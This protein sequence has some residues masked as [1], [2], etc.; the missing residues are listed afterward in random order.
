M[1][2][3]VARSLAIICAIAALWYLLPDRVAGQT[4]VLPMTGRRTR[5]IETAHLF[6]TLFHDF[7]LE[8]DATTYVQ[9]GDIPAMWLRDSSAQT[10]PYIRYQAVY[11][12]LRARFA[13]VIERNA[14]NVLTDP[15]ANALDADYHVW[16]RKWEVDSPAWPVV[17]AW[18]Y[19]RSTQDRTVFTP[20]LHRALRTI[21]AT[22]DC[23]ERHR[24]CSRYV[25]PYRVQTDDTYNGGTG[26]IWGAFRPSDDAV[27]F[28]F[29]IPQNAMAV[30]AL[31]D[32]ERLALDGYGDAALANRARALEARVQVGIE[33]YGRYFDTG[34]H[35]WMYAYETDG[36]G[37]YNLMDDANIPN[38][39]TLPYIDWCSAFDP[40]YLATRKFALSAANPYFFSGRY[41]EGLGSPHTPYGY[42]WPLGIIGSALTATS[43][44]EVANAITTLAETDG[45]SGLF[46]ESFYPNGYWRYTRPEFGWANA[47]GA[48]LLFRSLAGDSA[49]QFAWNGPLEPFERRSRTPTLVPM[50]VQ[51]Q[52]AAELNATLGRLLHVTGG[53]M[54]HAP[55]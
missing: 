15:Y 28:R 50:L 44:A 48:E 37:R 52:N 13:G 43:S 10:I 38:L 22:Y 12:V 31:R 45:E 9:T 1:R 34:R 3:L 32:I 41:A 6:H 26:L 23:E 30:V 47:V 16:E 40:T 14:R 55:K 17:L 2:L 4:L 35:V 29:N 5:A 7:F 46:H 54:P 53:A 18:V 21:V 27:R 11:P 20:D 33:R 39:T 51:I 24:A 8:D 36:F 49:T 42:V 19:W 25:Y